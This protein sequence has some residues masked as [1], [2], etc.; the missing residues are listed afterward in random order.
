MLKTNSRQCDSAN[1]AGRNIEYSTAA[2]KTSASATTAAEASATLT[3]AKATAGT[4]TTA[5]AETSASA[6]AATEAAATETT[7]AKATPSEPSLSQDRN[8]RE[9]AWHRDRQW[10]VRFVGDNHVG[11]LFTDCLDDNLD[12]TRLHRRKHLG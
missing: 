12:V 5:A 8:S 7:T 3:T 6:T 11:F 4:L 2:T 1:F 10:L 9:R